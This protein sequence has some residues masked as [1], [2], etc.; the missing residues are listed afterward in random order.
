MRVV[1]S[2]I[3]TANITPLQLDGNFGYL[4]SIYL[5]ILDEALSAVELKE[6]PV[7]FDRALVGCSTTP[8]QSFQLPD[9]P[10]LERGLVKR[11]YYS[12]LTVALL[13]NRPR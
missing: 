6:Q 3:G 9:R 12:R 1:P 11:P 7:E 5:V 2:C 8:S 10:R 13:N 4:N